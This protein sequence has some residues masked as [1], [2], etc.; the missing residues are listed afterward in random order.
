MHTARAIPIVRHG[1]G[2]T[3]PARS[4]RRR[5]DRTRRGAGRSKSNHAVSDGR[6]LEIERTRKRDH[7]RRQ[8]APSAKEQPSAGPCMSGKAQVPR[9][10]GSAAAHGARVH[11]E[12]SG[13]GAT[14]CGPC[15][16][17]IGRYGSSMSAGLALTDCGGNRA[18]LRSTYAGRRTSRGG[19]PRG[20]RGTVRVGGVRPSPP[21][22]PGPSCRSGPR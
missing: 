8:A 2:R 13:R 1:A 12:R 11:A 19:F 9:T 22:A 3:G 15:Y 6:T 21:C 17:R 14:S 18:T 20:N 10:A 5:C 4:P 7:R 16:R